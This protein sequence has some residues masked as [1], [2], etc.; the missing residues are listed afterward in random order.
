MHCSFCDGKG[1]PTDYYSAAK[2][3][4]LISIGF[5]SHAP[6]P[7]ET[8]WAMK[9]ES[10]REYLASVNFIKSFPSEVEIYTGLEVDYIP[11]IISPVDYTRQLD[12][13]IGS[14]HFVE[15]FDD[16]S[17]F[18]IDGRYDTFLRGFDTIFRSDIRALLHRYYDLLIE[19]VRQANPTIVGH[20]DK[21]KIQNQNRAL[22][23][24]TDEWYRS[25]ITRVVKEIKLT[26][27]IVEINTRGIYQKKSA[28]VYPSPW[29]IELLFENKIPV[30]INSDAHNPAD[31]INGFPETAALLHKIGYRHLSVLRDGIWQS[32]PFDQ[33]GIQP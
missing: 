3:N 10:L 20:L 30:T 4:K 23:A 5:S 13:T 16:G 27:S 17:P 21:I 11:G 32:L 15:S 1:D 33:H 28:D 26:G 29:I 19:M 24:E 12:Y 7:F 9:K 2:R 31:I 14:I 18:E 8:G 25:M 6:V 22:F